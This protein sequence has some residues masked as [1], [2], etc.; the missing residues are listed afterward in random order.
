MLAGHWKGSHN[1]A[2]VAVSLCRCVTNRVLCPRNT[3]S[4]REVGVDEVIHLRTNDGTVACCAPKRTANADGWGEA[5]VS[6]A[7]W[8]PTC[9]SCVASLK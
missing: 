2:C 8:R 9:P 3:K 5:T 6:R 1:S 4:L 7:D